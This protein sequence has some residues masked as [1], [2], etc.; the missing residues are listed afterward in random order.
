MEEKKENTAKVNYR[1]HT[2][3]WETEGE[4]NRGAIKGNERPQQVY[5]QRG[6]T[7]LLDFT[8]IV[9]NFLIKDWSILMNCAISDT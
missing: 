6:N 9:V 4:M 8:V 1:T 7:V 3:R 5:V 2:G